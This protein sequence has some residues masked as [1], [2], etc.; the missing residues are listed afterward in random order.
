MTPQNSGR[1]DLTRSRDPVAMTCRTRVRRRFA[2]C[3]TIPERPTRPPSPREI[4]SRGRPWA[5][6]DGACPRRRHPESFADAPH[7]ESSETKQSNL[8][9]SISESANAYWR[10]TNH[11][12]KLHIGSV[13][14]KKRAG[15]RN[16]VRLCHAIAATPK[17]RKR[18]FH[19][20]C[21]QP[22]RRRGANIHAKR[23]EF[24]KPNS[25]FANHADRQLFSIIPFQS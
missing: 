21:G 17:P 25:A 7:R 11:L 22:P 2:A 8:H 9:P 19:A 24:P 4:P 6:L 18:P 13:R 1:T 14:M 15:K 20:A 3:Q 10:H 5:Q 23:N 16:Y 12:H